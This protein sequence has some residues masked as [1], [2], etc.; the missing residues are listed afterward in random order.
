MSPAPQ[1]LLETG[2]PMPW[3]DRPRFY[4]AHPE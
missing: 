4:R 1:W 2:L 3:L